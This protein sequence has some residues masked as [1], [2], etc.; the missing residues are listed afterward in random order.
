MDRPPTQIS[1]FPLDRT[2]N[3]IDKRIDSIDERLKLLEA[4]IERRIKDAIKQQIASHLAELAWE[5]EKRSS[6]PKK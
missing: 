1:R 4:S 3:H 6:L 5:S 2:A